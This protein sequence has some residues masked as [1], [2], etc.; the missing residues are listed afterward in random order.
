M[1][2]FTVY[3]LVIDMTII[4]SLATQYCFGIPKFHLLQIIITVLFIGNRLLIVEIIDV[5]DQQCHFRYVEN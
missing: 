5:N 2:E 1:I 3:F 4:A